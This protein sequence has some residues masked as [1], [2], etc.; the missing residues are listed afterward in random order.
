M[1]AHQDEEIIEDVYVYQGPEY[2]GLLVSSAY[3]LVWVNE[4]S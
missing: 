3:Y 1:T 2:W 4:R